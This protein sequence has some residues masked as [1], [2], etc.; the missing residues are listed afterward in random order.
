MEVKRS[1]EMKVARG[2]NH[3]RERQRKKERKG[4][5]RRRWGKG[6]R[7]ETSVIVP[8]KKEEAK[9]KHGHEQGETA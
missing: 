2:S 1:N 7:K 6:A 8:N 9:I 4:K 3:G 5:E